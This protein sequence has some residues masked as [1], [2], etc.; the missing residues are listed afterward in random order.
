MSLTLQEFERL[1]ALS[2]IKLSSS[3]KEKF[4][5]KMNGIID[6]IRSV[7]SIAPLSPFTR[8]ELHP[9]YIES[10][11]ERFSDA[12]ALFANAQHEK[13]GNG[14]VIKSVFD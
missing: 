4:L 6:F 13:A 3:E 12:N 1:E 9:M 14:I 10:S 7:D 5:D 2:Y 8:G 11:S